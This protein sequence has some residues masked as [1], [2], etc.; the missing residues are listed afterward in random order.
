[1]KIEGIV[2]LGKALDVTQP[3]ELDESDTLHIGKRVLQIYHSVCESMHVEWKLNIAFL[4][5]FA[6]SVQYG[7]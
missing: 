3:I 6:L 2:W 4:K 7:F 1:M 5:S